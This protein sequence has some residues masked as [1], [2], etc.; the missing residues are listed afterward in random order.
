MGAAAEGHE[1]EEAVARRRLDVERHLAGGVSGELDQDADGRRGGGGEV[2]LGLDELFGDNPLTFGAESGE[3]GADVGAL[4]DPP[5]GGV[6]DAGFVGGGLDRLAGE[7]G[8]DDL[9]VRPV[10]GAVFDGA[11]SGG[12]GAHGW[13]SSGG[14]G[15]AWA[16]GPGARR[17]SK[18]YRSSSEQSGK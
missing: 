8:G 6:G 18:P 5:A 14:G 12:H 2:L 1:G 10:A 13:A 3:L 17:T 9:I 11:V 4:Q 16:V 15:H 7:D